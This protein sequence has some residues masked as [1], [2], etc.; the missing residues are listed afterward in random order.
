[1]IDAKTRQQIFIGVAV[2]V[3]SYMIISVL[4]HPEDF[5][6]VLKVITIGSDPIKAI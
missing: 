1:M 6:Q 5:Q 2:A 4:Q 3:I